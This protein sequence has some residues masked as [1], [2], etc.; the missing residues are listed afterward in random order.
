[1]AGIAHQ[2]SCHVL[3]HLGDAQ[4]DL[5]V[6]LHQ[7]LPRLLCRYMVGLGSYQRL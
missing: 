2:V 5:R 1:M 7:P 6:S 3:L 4:G